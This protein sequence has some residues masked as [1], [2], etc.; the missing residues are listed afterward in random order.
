MKINFKK[1]FLLLTLFIVS[2]LSLVTF[3]SA[4]QTPSLNLTLSPSLL[5][6]SSPPDGTINGQF[7][8][9]NNLSKPV[10]LAISVDRLD[11]GGD[12]SI[13]PAKAQA[14]D[15]Y[16]SWLT[17]E[18]NKLTAAPQE[19]T[20]I[21]YSIKIPKEAAFGYYYAIRISQT[22][23]AQ[24]TN[25][26]VL[27]EVVL[28]LL[29]DVKKDGSKKEI[30]LVEFKTN[31]FV[32]EYLPV[33]F[34]TTVQNSGNVHIKPLGNI[35]I[36]GTKE[37]DLGVI[38]V[39]PN[40]GTV[41][42]GN[43]RTLTAKWD[44]GFL[45]KENVLEDGSPKLDKNNKPLTHLAIHWNKLTA[46]RIGKYTANLLLVYDNGKK[47]IPIEATTEFWIIPYTAIAIALGAII[48]LFIIIRFMLK[49]YI[50]GQIKKAQNK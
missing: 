43:K 10:T 30:K 13:K 5:D 9:R 23:E 41:L 31:Q 37:K 4:Q 14:A 29:L 21:K 1:S 34:V 32:N 47:D 38:D 2:A 50:Q 42:P 15:A 45:V 20:N 36:R 19:W 35:F 11:A 7:R 33:E 39:N 3:A 49:A 27:G 44:D 18:N 48:V 17:F 46:F 26:T 16:I 6:I 24:K 8:L 22:G 25:T 28:P 12:G 40:L